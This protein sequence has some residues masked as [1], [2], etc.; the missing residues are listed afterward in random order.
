MYI[1]CF[2]NE[3]AYFDSFILITYRHMTKLIFLKINKNLILSDLRA[4]LL[5]LKHK[6]LQENN[7]INI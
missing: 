7:G 1:V 2:F 3:F 6:E 5:I 4:P